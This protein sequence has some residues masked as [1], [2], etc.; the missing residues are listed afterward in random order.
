M[1]MQSCWVDVRKVT[2]FRQRC[3]EWRMC[4]MAIRW[5][6]GQLDLVKWGEASQ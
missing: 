4:R 1:R 3:R 5:L 6:T 2:G